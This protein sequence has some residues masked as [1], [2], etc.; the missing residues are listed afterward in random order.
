MHF[1]IYD[2]IY[3]K[4]A[5]Q[6]V[7]AGLLAIFKAMLLSQQ[8]KSTN[9]VSCVDYIYIYKCSKTHRVLPRIVMVQCDF[10]W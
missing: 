8:Y 4:Y 3:S 7:S 1:N 9:V 10:H 2:Q 5:Q 6:H